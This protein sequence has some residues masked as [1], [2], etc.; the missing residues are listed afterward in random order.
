M[1]AASKVARSSSNLAERISRALLEGSPVV[2][3][4]EK[5]ND[6]SESSRTNRL[7]SSTI[8]LNVAVQQST[9]QY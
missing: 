6:R 7:N 3:I 5:V 4:V 8:K 2:C 1:R 9:I